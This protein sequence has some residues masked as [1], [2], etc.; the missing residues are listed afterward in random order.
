MIA[1]FC[2]CI[3]LALIWASASAA[4][5]EQAGKIPRLCFLGNST[6]ELEANLI[7]PFREGLRSHGYIEGKT[8]SLSGDGLRDNTRNFQS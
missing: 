8:S 3:F 1:R 5:A 2:S 4:Q 7:G 6:A